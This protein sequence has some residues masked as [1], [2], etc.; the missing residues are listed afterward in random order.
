M[1]DWINSSTRNSKN[2]ICGH[3]GNNI[4][5]E[6]GYGERNSGDYIYICHKCGK[7]TYFNKLGDQ[8][9][10]ALFGK[11][12]DVAIPQ[13]VKDLY[14]EA[15]RCYSVNAFTSVGMCCRKLFFANKMCAE[16]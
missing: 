15:R 16:S 5:S 7:P 11:H 8:I 2:Y 6:K 4:S 1:V 10:G 12:F 14:E 13:L 9:P 3:C